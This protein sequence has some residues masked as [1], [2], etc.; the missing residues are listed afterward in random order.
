MGI[1]YKRKR[2]AKSFPSINRNPGLEFA[3]A[4]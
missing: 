3:K 2:Y 1:Q 4:K